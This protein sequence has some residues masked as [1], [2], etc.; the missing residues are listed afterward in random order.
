MVKVSRRNKL[1]GLV[2]KFRACHG[3]NE[4]GF[5][6]AP[7][8]MKVS[9]NQRVS[10]LR[11]YTKKFYL[12]F[13]DLDLRLSRVLGIWILLLCFFQAF[14]DQF[15]INQYFV[16]VWSLCIL[17]SFFSKRGYLKEVIWKY[18]YQSKKHFCGENSWKGVIPNIWGQACALKR[19]GFGW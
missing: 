3:I 5:A 8:N 18:N 6:V 2:A 4:G 16:Q 19:M 9:F 7:K 11:N 10:S 15:A 14:E 12:S 1:C 17:K 13:W